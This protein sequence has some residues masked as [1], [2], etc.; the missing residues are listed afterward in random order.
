MSP[1][2]HE[3]I[4]KRIRMEK[5][6]PREIGLLFHLNESAM[7]SEIKINGKGE[8]EILGEDGKPINIDQAFAEINYHRKIKRRL[9]QEWLQTQRNHLLMLKMPLLNLIAYL[10]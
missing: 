9:F 4:K 10:Q 8:I 2:G 3:E 7:I 6:K 1:I 5:K